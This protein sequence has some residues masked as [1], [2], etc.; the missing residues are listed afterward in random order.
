MLS[1]PIYLPDSFP[2]VVIIIIVVVT[3]NTK[4]VIVIVS[5]AYQLTTSA[6][7]YCSALC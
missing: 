3:S 2:I 5:S 4:A 1:I 6:Q 7:I